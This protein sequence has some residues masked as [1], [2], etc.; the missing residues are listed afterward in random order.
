MSP[1]PPCRHL[2]TKAMY[3]PAEAEHALDAEADGS[4]NAA[5]WCNRTQTCLGLDEHL[6]EPAACQPGRSCYEPR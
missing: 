4:A 2:R 5:F 1:L 6:A 3:I